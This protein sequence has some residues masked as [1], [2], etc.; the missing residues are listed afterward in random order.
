MKKYHQTDYQKTMSNTVQASAIVFLVFITGYYAF[1]T[2]IKTMNPGVS[3][4]IISR[5]K[6]LSYKSPK[7]FPILFLLLENIYFQGSRDLLV[8]LASALNLLVDRDP[9]HMYILF[10]SSRLS[11]EFSVAQDQRL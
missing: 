11:Y 5:N 3:F 7:K 6:N 1:Q 9:F 8:P 4:P 2:V 10:G